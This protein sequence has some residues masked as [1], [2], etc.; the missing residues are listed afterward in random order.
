MSTID[1]NK[2]E[3][4]FDLENAEKEIKKF[5][6][7]VDNIPDP[8]SAND[9]LKANIKRANHLLDL[10]E[11]MLAE[12]AM[13]PRIFELS[14][15]LI[16]SITSASNSLISSEFQGYTLDLKDKALEIKKTEVENKLKQFDQNNQIVQQNN[17]IAVGN[18][19]ELLDKIFNIE[20]K[21]PIKIEAQVVE[22][23]LDN[24]FSLP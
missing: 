1:L 3:E 7:I 14:A 18:R 16:D 23:K 13:S 11:D 15:K 9:I 2:L 24:E 21:D 12:G 19:E 8:G 4:E 6:D 5:R 22:N 10:A 20:Q 17:I